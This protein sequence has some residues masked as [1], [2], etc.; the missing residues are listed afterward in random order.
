[1][2]CV[3][4][5]VCVYFLVH[6]REPVPDKLCLQNSYFSSLY[7]SISNFSDS[8]CGSQTYWFNLYPYEP[9]LKYK[10]HILYYHG[11]V[12]PC[13]LNRHMLYNIVT[14]GLILQAELLF[15]WNTFLYLWSSH[16]MCVSCFDTHALSYHRVTSISSSN[17]A[18][19]YTIYL[20]SLR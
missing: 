5:C 8:L 7:P 2:V 6:G 10:I 1:M 17:S 13:L 20:I 9:P 12:M 4:V 19:S 11:N 3:C 16:R 18:S 15:S 14:Q